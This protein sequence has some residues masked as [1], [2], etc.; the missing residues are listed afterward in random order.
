MDAMKADEEES[1]VVVNIHVPELEAATGR[2][3]RMCMKDA[4]VS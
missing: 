1:N 4:T 3:M 2:R